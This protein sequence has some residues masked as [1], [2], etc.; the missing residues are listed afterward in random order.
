M[1]PKRPFLPRGRNNTVQNDDGW[2]P[3]LPPSPLPPPQAREAREKEE[4]A[5][6]HKRR[7]LDYEEGN[8][9]HLASL[10][11][12]KDALEEQLRQ[13][14]GK[15]GDG[16]GR[17]GKGEGRALEEQLRQQVGKGGD[18]EG[19]GRE[20]KGGGGCTGGSRW[21]G[22]GHEEFG[23]RG[24]RSPAPSCP[25]TSALPPPPLSDLCCQAQLGGLFGAG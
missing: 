10:R 16:E 8:A 1:N 21:R 2:L 20:G 17:E 22:G 6:D 25:P 19:E 12:E 5:L 7:M 14:V 18:G 24:G 15:G 9:A 13:Q 11:R 3:S 23:G 4:A